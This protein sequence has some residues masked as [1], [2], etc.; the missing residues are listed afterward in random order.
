[1]ARR[2]MVAPINSIKHFVHHSPAT[3]VAGAVTSIVLVNAVVAPAVATTADVIQGAIVK[4]VYIEV[5]IGG[6]TAN[7]T[8][9][10]NVTVEKRVANAPAMTFTQSVNLQ[11]YPN[12]K[13]I[14]YTTQGIIGPVSS[15]GGTTPIIR[16]WIKIPK[17]KQRFGLNDEFVIN[18]S[19]ITNDMIA[20]GIFIFKEYR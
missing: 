20:C 2:R 13:N 3:V 14:L 5:W 6:N 4:A 7:A 11:S 18:L 15:G 1:M 12:K 10:F 9:S 16:D 17:G 8:S 19:N